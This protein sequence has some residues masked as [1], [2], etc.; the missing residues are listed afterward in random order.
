MDCSEKMYI[1]VEDLY[2]VADRYM[3]V[4][5]GYDRE[6]GLVNKSK[7][8]AYKVRTKVFS[9]EKMPFLIREF[10]RESI[11]GDYF[12]IDGQRI[13][14]EALKRI[15]R[16]S[17]KGGFAFLFHSPMPDI[18]SLPISQMYLADSWET[19]FVDAGRDLL[20]Q[21]LLD[22]LG[23]GERELLYITDSLAPGM[24]GIP[25]EAVSSFFHI[26]DAS[27]IDMFLLASGMMSP[28]KSFAGIYLII[29]RKAVLKTANCNECVSN[30]KF[31][32]YCKNYARHYIGKDYERSI[33]KS[34]KS[35]MKSWMQNAC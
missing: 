9:G 15:D 5:C 7:E 22:K 4:M 6:S 18:Y 27:Q 26:F 11:F 29:D 1:D 23:A 21:Q 12:N 25:A 8:L 2:E 17:I 16:K 33:Q 10:G 19:C 32:E 35:L 20:R 31:C 24:A 28:V 34:D 30:H 3:G 13:P 14:C